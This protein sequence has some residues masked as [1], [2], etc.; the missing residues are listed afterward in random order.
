M[1]V[2][3]QDQGSFLFTNGLPEFVGK[4]VLSSLSHSTPL[5]EHRHRGGP[6]LL[7]DRHRLSSAGDLEV[8]ASGIFLFQK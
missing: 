4:A 3:G 5:S 6:A 7:K 2:Q 8:R 1:C